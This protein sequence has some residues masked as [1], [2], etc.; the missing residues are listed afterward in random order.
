VRSEGTAHS[1]VHVLVHALC[2][3]SS[4]WGAGCAAQGLNR[5]GCQALQQQDSWN[6]LTDNTR[7][8]LSAASK[9]QAHPTSCQQKSV[10]DTHLAV[11]APVQ[12]GI[13]LRLAVRADLRVVE[14]SSTAKKGQQ[15]ARLACV[16]AAC[17]CAG[18][19]T[20]YPPLLAQQRRLGQAVAAGVRC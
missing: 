16:L 3:C 11:V 20:P 12:R 15:R 13:D 8:G 14:T 9:P 17:R 19:T 6:S 18:T 5:L 10:L 7:L 1:P 4:D 2:A